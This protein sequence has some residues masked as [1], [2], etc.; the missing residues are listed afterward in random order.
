MPLP[1]PFRRGY[2]PQI[3]RI[4]RSHAVARLVIPAGI[5]RIP[6]FSFPVVFFFTGIM[7]PVPQKHFRSPLRNTVYMGPK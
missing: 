7:S 1:N 5:L 2:S 6:V 3:G 4:H